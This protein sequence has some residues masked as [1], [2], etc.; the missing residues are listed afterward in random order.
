[1][2]KTLQELLKSARGGVLELG[3]GEYRGP[4][5]VSKPVV[6]KG[7]GQGTTIIASGGPVVQVRSGSV[8]L[9][10]L[11]IEHLDGDDGVAVEAR[12]GTHPHVTRCIVVGRLVGV[13]DRDVSL[14]YFEVAAPPP[15]DFPAPSQRDPGTPGGPPTSPGRLNRLQRMVSKLLDQAEQAYLRGAID[16][17]IAYC[18]QAL[19]LEP[20]N[21]DA[22]ALKVRCVALNA[23]QA[24][25]SAARQP[26]RRGRVS[27]TP[28]G[29]PRSQGPPTAPPRT[30]DS[31]V[32]V[33][34]TCPYCHSP[35]EVP[36]TGHVMCSRCGGIFVGL[37]ASEAPQAP[38]A[39]DRAEAPQPQTAGQ[40]RGAGMIRSICPWCG[41]RNSSAR[42]GSVICASCYQPF[43]IDG[44][45]NLVP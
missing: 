13:R 25:T 3:F 33:G 34:T 8:E 39:R 41:A 32:A 27:A 11:M 6:I 35:V 14:A 7:E 21:K 36:S 12:R 23:A 5:V 43:R 22:Q 17:A 2:A 37:S 20:A 18:D 45:G 29:A 16:D 30:P 9:R 15:L 42:P 24:P 19:G 1:M 44:S 31:S 28:S 4:V 40:R 10:D 38:S 26:V